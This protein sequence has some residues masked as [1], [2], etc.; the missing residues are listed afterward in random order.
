ML[1]SV[2]IG[3]F[4]GGLQHFADSLGHKPVR[5]TAIH[6]GMKKRGLVIEAF[7][8]DAPVSVKETTVNLNDT[9]CALALTQSAPS[10]TNRIPTKV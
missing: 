6:K 2:G 1:A 7:F 3:I 8:V 10:I 9:F 4:T 5:S